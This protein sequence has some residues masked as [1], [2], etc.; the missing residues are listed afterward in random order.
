VGSAASA[1]VRGN[2]TGRLGLFFL[3]LA[4]GLSLTGA[5][6]NFGRTAAPEL[7]LSD[8]PLGFSGD[9]A[10]ARAAE[11]AVAF[12]HRADGHPDREAA[13]R[14]LAD[15]FVALGY[16]PQLQG[17]GAWIEG[18]FHGDLANVWAVRPGRSLETVAV[19]AHYDIPPFAVQ[20]AADDASG[21]GTIL[22]LARVFAAEEPERTILFILT[23]T[24]EYGMAG[25]RAFLSRR[26]Y[27][28]PIVAGVGL[29]F[30]HPGEPAAIGVGFNGTH[31]GYTPPWLRSVGVRAAG[32]FAEVSA[33]ATLEEWIERSVAVS[34]QDAGMFLR[35]AVPVLNLQ[36]LPADPAAAAAVYHTPYDTAGLLEAEAFDMWGRT[37]ELIVRTVSDTPDLPGGPAAS[38]VHFGLSVDGSAAEYLPAWA[39]RTVEFLLLTPLWVS[40]GVGWYRRRRILRPVVGI[41]LAQARRVL[42]LA[43]CLALGLGALKLMRLVGILARYELYP[44]TSKDPYLYHPAVAPIALALLV[45]A[46]AF[47]LVKRFTG[48]LAPPLAADWLERHHAVTSLLAVL[49]L[50][51][52]LEGAG[53]AAVTFFVLPA[54]LWIIL[55]EPPPGAGRAGPVVRGLA[56][57]LVAAST[58]V[59]I[60]LIVVFGTR[61]PVGPLWWYLPLAATHGLISQKASL[62]FAVA[63]ALHWEVFLFAVGLGSGRVIPSVPAEERLP[64]TSVA[65]PTGSS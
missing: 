63:A 59:F 24:E 2:Y 15:Q 29:D 21:V 8:S 65:L 48:W 46:G 39:L 31:K 38:M 43:G 50:M 37:A 41:F 1:R 42:A 44:A 45:A 36:V 35:R 64:S 9:R 18:V 26:P 6:V 22:E 54:C 56:G 49:A 40:V 58:A 33:P 51:V 60:S 17:Y 47:Y 57:A 30:A 62:V 7:A 55:P 16:S 61:Y 14:W 11:F 34:A 3:A 32:R 52:W 4:V 19:F 28:G 12:P 27:L 10:L 5:L 20:G 23:D 53:C 25:A 13:A